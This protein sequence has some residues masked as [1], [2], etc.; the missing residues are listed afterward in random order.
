MSWTIQLG[1]W[2]PAERSATTAGTGRRRAR[3]PPPTAPGHRGRS[4]Q[5]AAQRPDGVRG[6]GAPGCP[7]RACRRATAGPPRARRRRPRSSTQSGAA[8]VVCAGKTR[9]AAGP[10][11]AQLGDGHRRDGGRAAAGPGR[12]AASAATTP[13]ST[14]SAASSRG[15]WARS[16][17]ACRTRCPRKCAAVG[18]SRRTCSQAGVAALPPYA[19]H[20]ADQLQV[21]EEHVRVVP[22]DRPEGAP[23]HRQ[24]ARPV[25]AERPVEQGPAGVPPGGPGQRVEVVLRPDQVHPVQQSCTARSP[26]SSYRTSSSAITTCSWRARS[27]PVSTPSD[28]AVGAA[29]RGIG[30]D[31]PDEIPP[32]GGVPGEELRRGAVDHGDV[33][34]SGEV[35]Q[36]VGQPGQAGVV[37]P[38][39]RQDVLDGEPTGSRPGARRGGRRPGPASTAAWWSRAGALMPPRSDGANARLPAAAGRPGPR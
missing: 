3:R 26:A 12:R 29:Q 33:H 1:D 36:V 5:P 27:S 31:V 18:G 20:G 17:Y 16:S 11:P 39:Q 37:G 15:G 38:A 14:A 35:A 6:D 7:R 22:A 28:L 34:P 30:G 2:P 25:A 21:L 32:G 4:G 10:P 8:S 9:G 23:A 19:P 13:G 24:G